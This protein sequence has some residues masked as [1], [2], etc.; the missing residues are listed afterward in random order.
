MPAGIDTPLWSVAI[1]MVKK[2]F[3][4]NSRGASIKAL[5][6]DGQKNAPLLAL[7]KRNPAGT[8]L[9]DLVTEHRNH[10]GFEIIISSHHQHAPLID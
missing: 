1:K 6:D 8:G 4:R 5:N 2:S 7:E 10:S 3:P 9:Q